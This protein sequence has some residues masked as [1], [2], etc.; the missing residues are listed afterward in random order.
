LIEPKRLWRRYFIG[1]TVFLYKVIPERLEDIMREAIAMW[2]KIFFL[3]FPSSIPITNR[4]NH[5]HPLPQNNRD[6]L[7]GC[8]CLPNRETEIIISPYTATR[9]YLRRDLPGYTAKV[10]ND[11]VA[12]SASVENA[13]LEGIQLQQLSKKFQT[14][15]ADQFNIIICDFWNTVCYK[16]TVQQKWLKKN[17][18]YIAAGF[19]IVNPPTE[20]KNFMLHTT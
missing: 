17:G 10:I 5:S 13:S 15:K 12:Y 7:G 11:D 19:N 16:L 18:S 4:G 8:E 3:F 20:W 2:R 6:L 14:N 9:K 1:N